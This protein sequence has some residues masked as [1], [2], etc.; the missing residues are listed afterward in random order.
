MDLAEQGQSSKYFNGLACCR[1]GG[2]MHMDSR[3]DLLAHPIHQML[4]VFPVGLLAMA[5]VFDLLAVAHIDA[6]SSLT[7]RR[8]RR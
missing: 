6:P 7:T 1:N 8:V 5:V 3:A 2:G 4:I